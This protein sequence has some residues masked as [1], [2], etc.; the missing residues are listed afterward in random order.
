VGLATKLGDRLS[1]RMPEE[2]PR[3]GFGDRVAFVL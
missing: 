1:G 2:V 3:S